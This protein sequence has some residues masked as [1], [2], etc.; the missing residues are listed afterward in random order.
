M[1]G[2]TGKHNRL[3]FRDDAGKTF[4]VVQTLA[5]DCYV[6]VKIFEGSTRTVKFWRGDLNATVKHWSTWAFEPSSASKRVLDTDFEITLQEFGPA[7]QIAL[8]V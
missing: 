7:F 3:Y 1:T 2:F 5:P 6:V 4:R 8:S